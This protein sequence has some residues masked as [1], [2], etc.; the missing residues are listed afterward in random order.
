[1]NC[2]SKSAIPGSGVGGFDRVGVERDGRPF[3]PVVIDDQVLNGTFHVIAESAAVGITVPE[4]A[5]QEPQGEFLVELI[6]GVRVFQ[7]LEQ[8]AMHGAGVTTHQ[9]RGRDMSLVGLPEWA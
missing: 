4:V 2:C 5:P 9:P 8:V 3:A 1:M 7:D 6:R